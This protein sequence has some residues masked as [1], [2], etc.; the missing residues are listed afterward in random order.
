MTEE[1]KQVTN[2]DSYSSLLK[3]HAGIEKGVG[4]EDLTAR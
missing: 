2:F 1:L 3:E 4:I